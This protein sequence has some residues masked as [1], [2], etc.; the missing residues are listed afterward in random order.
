[1]ESA[2]LGGDWEAGEKEEVVLDEGDVEEAV[3][4]C[5]TAAAGWLVNG[6]PRLGRT[7]DGFAGLW[8]L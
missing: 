4:E 1:M 2:L 6:G 8:V 3:D 7:E 5:G